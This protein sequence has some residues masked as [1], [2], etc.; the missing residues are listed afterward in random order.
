MARKTNRFPSKGQ[1]NANMTQTEKYD[2]V[3]SSLDSLKVKQ[4]KVAQETPTMVPTTKIIIGV[5]LITVV[6]FGFLSLGNRPFI[7]N[8]N[9]LTEDNDLEYIDSAGIDFTFQLLNGEEVKLSD[10]KGSPVFLDLFAT[11]CQPC[12]D[13]MPEFVTL[14][15]AYPHV[16]IL[17]ISIDETDSVWMLE[18][19]SSK[20]GVTWTVGRDTTLKGAENFKVSSIPTLAYFNSTGVLKKIEIG[21]HSYE[22]LA[23]WLA[24]G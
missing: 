24:E 1:T 9:R 19:F 21:I 23:S 11:W 18:Q 15:S 4:T 16:Q 6:T 10:Y 20:Y 12:K 3:L 2:D 7:T 5:V 22:I 17:S 14:K 8:Q 13:Q